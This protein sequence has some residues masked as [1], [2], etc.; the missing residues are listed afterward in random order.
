M[1]VAQQVDAAFNSCKL[2]NPR[3][4]KINEAEPNSALLVL[5]TTTG[6]NDPADSIAPSRILMIHN[7]LDPHRRE[8]R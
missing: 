2:V 3:R 7:P 8:P 1:I 4:P 5:Y 6:N